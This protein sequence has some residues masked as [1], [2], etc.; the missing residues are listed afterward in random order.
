MPLT[1]GDII[2]VI[3]YL[4]GCVLIGFYFAKV[5]GKSFESYFLSARAFSTPLVTATIVST[6]FSGGVMI[7]APA[8][9]FRYGVAYWI[10]L[11]GI[12]YVIR[13][14]AAFIGGRVKSRLPMNVKTM[15]DFLQTYYGG[16]ATIAGVALNLVY[17]VIR[18]AMQI[19][20]LS[21][22]F[23][24]V[25]SVDPFIGGILGTLIILLY[26]LPS[27]FFAVVFTD[28][29]QTTVM[30]IA[31]GLVIMFTLQ[32]FA[33]MGGLGILTDQL[34]PA[35]FDWTG[36]HPGGWFYMISAFLASGLIMYCSP[37]NYQRFIASKDAS[38]ARRSFIL[39][40]IFWAPF[41]ALG[42]LI[43]LLGRVI[44]P[45]VQSETAVYQTYFMVAPD[46]VRGF[47]LAGLFAAV[48][49]TADSHLLL[50]GANLSRDIYQRFINRNTDERRMVYVTRLSVALVVVF[51]LWTSLQFTHI[52]EMWVWG[53]RLYTSAFFVPIVGALIWRGRLSKRAGLPTIL[54]GTLMFLGGMALGYREEILHIVSIPVSLMVF[55]AINYA[56]R[57]E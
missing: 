31:Q 56:F 30:F 34:P 19:L 43:G 6:L 23:Q 49:S 11:A 54:V 45:D 28:L 46:I 8:F 29:L 40:N 35:Y 15:P 9:A 16:G 38:V 36:G 4:L 41:Y 57:K 55:A 39:A 20:T 22:L 14:P 53:A 5:A 52:F 17:N 26:V 21:F 25:F 37:E 50:A 24:L 47:W 42:G 2:V 48:M 33:E 44:F 27:G 3:A 10:G 32:K 18:F 1:T 12:S 13:I 51:S 7:G